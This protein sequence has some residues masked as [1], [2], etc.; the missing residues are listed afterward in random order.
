M[1]DGS[2]RHRLEKRAM[3]GTLIFHKQYYITH[4]PKGKGAFYGLQR[5]SA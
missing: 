2:A 4:I 5:T 3:G 1:G